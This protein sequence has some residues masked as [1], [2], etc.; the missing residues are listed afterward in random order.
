M[1]IANA[2]L[3]GRIR[4]AYR[5]FVIPELG[6]CL[7]NLRNL[8]RFPAEVRNFSVLQRAQ[9]SFRIY[10]A[11]YSIRSA[12]VFTR[13]MRPWREAEFHLMSRLRISKSSGLARFIGPPGRVI[14][15]AVPS[16]DYEL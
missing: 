11:F 14:T 6:Y 9:M 8:V 12:G 13:V 4:T 15:M 5:I 7:E 16:R 3:E 10:S 1:R 2:F